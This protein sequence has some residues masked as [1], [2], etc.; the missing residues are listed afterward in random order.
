[1]IDYSPTQEL[2]AQIETYF[3]IPTWKQVLM[4]LMVNVGIVQIS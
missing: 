1:M 2:S 4:V 3:L